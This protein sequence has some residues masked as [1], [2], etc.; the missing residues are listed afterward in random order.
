MTDTSS[1][2]RGP[3]TPDHVIRTKQKPLVV[4]LLAVADE[5]RGPALARALA[6]YQSD[7]RAYFADQCAAE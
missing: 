6:D 4:D 1:S 3:V 2:Q 7:Y 5:Q